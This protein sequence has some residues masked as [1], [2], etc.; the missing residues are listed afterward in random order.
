MSD[1]IKP[2]SIILLVIVVVSLPFRQD[3]VNDEAA[4]FV[5]DSESSHDGLPTQWDGKQAI[6]IFFPESNTHPEFST[7]V[8]MIDSDGE[9]IGVNDAL[10]S[11][12][13][14]VGGFEG[15]EQ[16]MDFMMDATRV[17]GGLLSVGYTMDPNWGPFVHTIGGLNVDEVQGDF[18]GAYWSLSH[19][20]EYS[21]VGI[22]DLTMSQGDVIS[23]EIATW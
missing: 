23:W 22:G 17:A 2:A 5:S 9:T 13:A 11:T 21:M 18:S 6:C 1:L 3:S 20:G 7:G 10:N 12:G 16:G 15:Y 8:T 14:C 4:K 19:N